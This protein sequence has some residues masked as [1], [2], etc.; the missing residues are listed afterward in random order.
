MDLSLNCLDLDKT[1]EKQTEK[2]TQSKKRGTK[3]RRKENPVN[4]TAGHS[5]SQKQL[6]GLK[7]AEI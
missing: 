7:S 6:C 4:W 2:Q 1:E 3:E 5:K